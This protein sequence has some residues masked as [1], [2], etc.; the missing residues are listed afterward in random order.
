MPRLRKTSRA[1][2]DMKATEGNLLVTMATV[3]GRRP[4][5]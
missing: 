5:A 4:L 2:T 1:P 3:C